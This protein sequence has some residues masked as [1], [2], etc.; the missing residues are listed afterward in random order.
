MPQL[1]LKIT[2]IK[3]KV[4]LFIETDSHKNIR[5]L[6]KR[7]VIH[8]YTERGG[9]ISYNKA[10]STVNKYV[11]KIVQL[12]TFTENKITLFLKIGIGSANA[13]LICCSSPGFKYTVTNVFTKWAFCPYLVFTLV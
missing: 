8:V 6:G 13:V 11:L 10:F 4:T 5:Q 12:Q 3:I 2:T 1:L 7:A 9:L